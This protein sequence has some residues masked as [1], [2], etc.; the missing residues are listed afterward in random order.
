MANSDC[1]R[2][3]IVEDE[4]LWR[5]NLLRCDYLAEL[6]TEC[7]QA[8][9]VAESY[10]SAKASIDD[11]EEFDLAITD[12]FLE[13]PDSQYEWNSLAR[14]LQRRNIPIIVVSG[15]I[16]DADHITRMINAFQVVGFFHKS[17]LD[18]HEFSN[19][20]RKILSGSFDSRSDR[21]SGSAIT[22]LHLSDLHFRDSDQYDRSVVVGALWR[23]LEHW[24]DLAISPD[25]IAIT[26]DIAYSGKAYEYEFASDF[27]DKLLIKTGL[28]KDRL[29]LVPGNHDVDRSRITPFARSTWALNDRDSA[30]GILNS[31]NSRDLFMERLAGYASFINDY[32]A[33]TVGHI[34]F[35][36]RG[37]F[38]VK[39]LN[40]GN[41]TAAILGL[42][43]AW[44]SGNAI[45]ANDGGV[46]DKGNLVLGEK[47]MRDAIE[48]SSGVDF[49]IAIMHHPLSYLNDFDNQ[50]VVRLMSRDC[51]FLLRGHLHESDFERKTS[52]QGDLIV[53]PSGA[54]YQ[55]RKL[56]NSYNLVVLDPGSRKA[57]VLFRR[58]SDM[59]EAWLKDLDVTGE[60]NDGEL[61]FDLSR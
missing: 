10:Q 34:K 25:F 58:Y 4:M 44:S 52:V 57:R 16:A 8:V 24:E 6:S 54:V 59:Q 49:R 32:F 1:P 13:D 29:F 35:D 23:D 27:L 53:I 15:K 30:R 36:S 61:L 11:S 21:R 3:L 31:R 51:N 60:D 47:Q 22:W 40:F 19:H 18:P 39:K 41:Y 28:G 45:L 7:E 55:D 38:Y 37:Y 56:V 2:I 48:Q 12:V 26:G 46:H 14:L 17:D 42:N 20:I 9:V 50:D 43:S 5:K 33:D